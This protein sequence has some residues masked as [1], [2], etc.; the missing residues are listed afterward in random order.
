M[1]YS[2]RDEL[3]E[4]VKVE[5]P[6]CGS[7]GAWLKHEGPDLWLR[8]LCGTNKL[9]S[10]KLKTA[11]VDN[12]DVGG[13]VTLPRAGSKLWDALQVVKA[14]GPVTSDVVTERVNLLRGDRQTVSEVSSQLTVLKHKSLVEA[15][16]QRKG[17][18]GGSTWRI[19]SRASTLLG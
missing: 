15:L 19:T 10:T 7:E 12:L 16:D 9:L 6:K 17:L 4:D 14:Y 2:P 5:C 13:A 8:C 1:S 18:A 3:G 11:T